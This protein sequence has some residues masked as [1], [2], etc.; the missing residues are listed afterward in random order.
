MSDGARPIAVLAGGGA[1]PG[2]LIEALRR[3]RENFRVLA[4]RGFADGGLVRRA[5]AANDLLDVKR[6]LATLAAWQPACVVMAGPVNRP[7]PSAVFSALAAYRNRRELAALMALGDDGL[8]GGVVRLLEDNGHRVAGVD[9]L[10]PEL[11]GSVGVRAGREPDAASLRAIGIGMDLLRTVS[12]FDA[13]QATVIG[14]QRV[15]AL[16]GPEGTDAMLRR[17]RFMR[18]TRRWRAEN[19]GVLVKTTKEGQDFRVDLPA[20]GP[21]TVIL[22]DKAGLDGVAYGAGRTLVIDEDDMLREAR[23]RG[24]FVLGVPANEAEAVHGG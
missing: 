24:L 4:F 7:R 1:L 6:T 12:R 2:A 9:T 3:R 5:D 20:I 15:I 21:R 10:A 18:F 16:E 11:L 17:V 19:R 8:L 22:A 23:R 14:G 13:G